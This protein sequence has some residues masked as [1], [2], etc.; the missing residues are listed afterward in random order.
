M[1]TIVIPRYSHKERRTNSATPSVCM[2]CDYPLIDLRVGKDGKLA[3]LWLWDNDKADWVRPAFK[4]DLG[5]IQFDKEFIEGYRDMNN[6][7]VIDGNYSFLFC[8][9]PRDLYQCS[10]RKLLKRYGIFLM[11]YEEITDPA[12]DWMECE[13]CGADMGITYDQWVPVSW[14]EDKKLRQYCR[15]QYPQAPKLAYEE[16]VAAFGKEIPCWRCMIEIAD[17]VIMQLRAENK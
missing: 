2:N 8:I 16:T 15:W 4:G 7:E 3:E 10:E 14:Q 9:R 12:H 5:S 1:I 13:F 11:Y 6:D 17:K